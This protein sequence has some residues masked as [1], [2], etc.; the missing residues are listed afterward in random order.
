MRLPTGRSLLLNPRETWYEP[1]IH[2]ILAL[3]EERCKSFSGSERSVKAI[4]STCVALVQ[5]IISIPSPFLSAI[6]SA[7]Y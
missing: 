5:R 7:P 6:K 1:L 4:F 3:S 2:R